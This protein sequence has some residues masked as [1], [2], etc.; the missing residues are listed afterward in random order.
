[1]SRLKTVV[2]IAACVL[3]ACGGSGGYSDEFR[4]T[5]LSSCEQSSG[6]Q[7]AYCRCA[8]DHLEANGPE[9]EDDI[10]AQD[11]TEAIQACAGEVTG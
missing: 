10:T 5:F 4:S 9:N 7:T 6:G 11:Q 1:M 8:L 2:A 3:A